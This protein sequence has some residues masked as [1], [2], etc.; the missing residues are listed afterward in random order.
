M[1]PLTDFIIIFYLPRDFIPNKQAKS[2]QENLSRQIKEETLRGTRL[3]RRAHPLKRNK[4]VIQNSQ[5]LFL[6]FPKAITRRK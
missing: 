2:S 3:K 5:C 4:I 6:F 1:T